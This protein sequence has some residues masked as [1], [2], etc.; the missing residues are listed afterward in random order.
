MPIS[1]S[2]LMLKLY[3]CTHP[4]LNFML[5]N[6]FEARHSQSKHPYALVENLFQE[7]VA[8]LGITPHKT[9]FKQRSM[10]FGQAIA[11]FSNVSNKTILK[12]F[13]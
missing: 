1:I 13:L 5:G 12:V 11:N 8:S 4:T 10:K 9:S 3:P 2:W 7:H 6:P